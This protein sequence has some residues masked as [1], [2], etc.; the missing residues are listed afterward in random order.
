MN[1]TDSL[2][3]CERIRTLKAKTTGEGEIKIQQWVP[4]FGC[5]DPKVKF[6]VADPWFL[7]L[8]KHMSQQGGLVQIQ[9]PR[10]LEK[11]LMQ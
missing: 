2:K 1:T 7:N 5:R 11:I 8:P 10:A 4:D 3:D 9:L 6:D